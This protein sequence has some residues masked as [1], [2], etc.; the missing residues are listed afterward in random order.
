MGYKLL[1]RYKKRP[2]LKT[3]RV[4]IMRC[5]LTQAL[6]KFVTAQGREGRDSAKVK[7]PLPTAPRSMKRPQK[8]NAR[9]SKNFCGN[10]AVLH[11]VNACTNS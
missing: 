1:V 8:Q 9:H 11:Y 2:P 5:C 6:H 7:P 3:L 4:E 10:N